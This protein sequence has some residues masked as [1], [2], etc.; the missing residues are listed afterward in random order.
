MQGIEDP[1]RSGRYPEPRWLGIVQHDQ[2]LFDHGV[3]AEAEQSP[4]A[5]I[6]IEYKIGSDMAAASIDLAARLMTAD[7]LYADYP[8]EATGDMGNTDSVPFQDDCAAVS[9]RENRR[10]AEMP[11]GAAPHWHQETDRYETY[12]EAD[13]RFGFQTMRMTVGAIATLVGVKIDAR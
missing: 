5:D 6:D 9:V 11:N 2:I 8:A 3:P 10:R 1:P 13:F 7:A 12:S 4:S